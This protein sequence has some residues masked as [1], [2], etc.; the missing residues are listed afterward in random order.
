MNAEERELL[1]RLISDPPPGSKI[2]AALDY[3]VDLTLLLRR[4]EMTPTERVQELAA[5]QAFVEEL[6]R[7]KRRSR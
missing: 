1:I 3:G 4:L 5:A 6:Q 7:A 2:A